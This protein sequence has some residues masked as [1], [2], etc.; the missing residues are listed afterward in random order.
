MFRS[1]KEIRYQIAT[2]T[3][4]LLPPSQLKMKVWR[5]DL[6]LQAS[7]MGPIGQSRMAL[8][9]PDIFK[10]VAFSVLLGTCTFYCGQNLIFFTNFRVCDRILS[11]CCLFSWFQRLIILLELL[12][13]RFLS[14]VLVVVT[15]G[16]LVAI[17]GGLVFW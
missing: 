9:S 12:A 13:D 14:A 8:A 7:A 6:G 10:S 1:M 17:S 5:D 2:K 3:T 4:L 16:V 15:V 11:L